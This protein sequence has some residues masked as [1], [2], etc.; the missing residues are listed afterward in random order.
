MSVYSFAVA[1]HAD[2]DGFDVAGDEGVEHHTVDGEGGV[3]NGEETG[4]AGVDHDG[5]GEG[6]QTGCHLATGNMACRHSL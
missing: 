6:K 5:R 3:L 4:Q 1:G 2:V